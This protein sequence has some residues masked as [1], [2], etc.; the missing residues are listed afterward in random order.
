MLPL[1]P[2]LCALISFPSH[3]QETVSVLVVRA[4]PATAEK[5]LS[6]KKNKH[7]YFRVAREIDSLD[8]AFASI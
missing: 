8:V 4:T 7:F 3:C 6:W 1:F 5:N 2:I